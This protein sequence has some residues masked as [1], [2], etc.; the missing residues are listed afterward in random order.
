MG[1]FTD[2]FISGLTHRIPHVLDSILG[3]VGSHK[4]WLYAYADVIQY[5]SVY[6]WWKTA[7]FLQTVIFISWVKCLALHCGDPWWEKPKEEEEEG[8]NV[9]QK[10]AIMSHHTLELQTVTWMIW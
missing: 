2:V 8:L 3:W 9:W 10:K 7:K 5:F 4:D 1:I 6:Q